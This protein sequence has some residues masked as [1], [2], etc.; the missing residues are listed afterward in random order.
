MQQNIYI[1]YWKEVLILG[2][3]YQM[4]ENKILNTTINAQIKIKMRIHAFERIKRFDSLSNSVFLHF[5][6]KEKS[7]DPLNVWFEN[8]SDLLIDIEQS[9]MFIFVWAKSNNGWA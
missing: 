9:W 5:K 2:L 3:L 7:N 6:I 4:H 1:N 8:I